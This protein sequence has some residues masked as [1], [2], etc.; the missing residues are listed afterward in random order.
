MLLAMG[1]LV[2]FFYFLGSMDL[3][4]QTGL[5]LTTRLLS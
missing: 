3:K 4:T 5:V 1:S 2:S